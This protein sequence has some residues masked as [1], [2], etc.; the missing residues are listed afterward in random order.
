MLSSPLQDWNCLFELPETLMAARKS[1]VQLDSLTY[2]VVYNSV[3][4]CGLT[5]PETLL[6]L[7]ILTITMYHSVL[8]Y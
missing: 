6:N 8:L 2:F 3:L 1:L 4:L 5:G 7:G